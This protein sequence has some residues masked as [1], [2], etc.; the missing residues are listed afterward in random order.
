MIADVSGVEIRRA[1]PEDASSIA[2]MH[3]ASARA[4]YSTFFPTSARKP[5]SRSLEPGWEQL[6]RSPGAFVWVACTGGEVIGSVAI[7]A[8]DGVPSGLALCRL[9]VDPDWRGQS[10]GTALHDAALNHARS[11]SHGRINLWVLQR[12]GRARVMYERL[13]WRYMPGPRMGN[14]VPGV[15]DVLYELHLLRSLATD[16]SATNVR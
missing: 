10:I 3:C 4:G 14:A 1:W 2:R 6:L 12:N 13:G 5:T 8:D 15:F 7:A 16:K 11:G 9:Y